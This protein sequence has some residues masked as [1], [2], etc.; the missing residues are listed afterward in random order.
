MTMAGKVGTPKRAVRSNHACR[1]CRTR[2]VKCDSV[3]PICGLCRTENA[4]CVYEQDRRQTSRVSHIVIQRLTE[5]L[6]EVE[7]TVHRLE[8]SLSQRPTGQIQTPP[9]TGISILSPTH[10]TSQSIDN[11]LMA[12]IPNNSE[13]SIFIEASPSDQSLDEKQTTPAEIHTGVENDGGH[14]SVYGPSSTFNPPLSSAV[15]RQPHP[16]SL[17]F[18]FPHSA[19]GLSQSDTEDTT[20]EQCRLF[21]NSAFQIQKE[22]TYMTERRFDLDGLDFDT[23]WHLL[24]IH[25]NH[26]HQAYLMTYRPAIMH[27]LATNGPYINKLL[28]NAIYLSSA[29]NSNRD[30]LHDGP[31]DQQSLSTKFFSRIQELTLSELENSSVASAVAFLII[32]SSLVSVGRQTAGWHYSGLGYR[33]IIDL[34]L[35]IDPHKL[36]ISHSDPS[37]PVRSFTEVDLELH[38]RVYWGAYIND[39][40]QALYFGRPP[41]LTAIGIEPSRAYLDNFEELELW[42]PYVDPRSSVSSSSTFQPQPAYSLSTFQT[43]IYLTDIMTDVVS[44]LYS[45]QVQCLSQERILEIG[46]DLQERLE[47]WMSNLPDHLRWEPSQGNAPP[48]HR[49]NPPS[50][51]PFDLNLSQDQT[52]NSLTNTQFF[53][54]G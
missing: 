37:Q 25:W 13:E 22:W 50:V 8:H 18:S 34:G 9:D 3:H 26:H 51:V 12:T 1:L 43:F 48:A 11:V 23:A 45:P 28:L 44:S 17:G 42:K 14:I 6:A 20:E 2:K 15:Y 21:A 39:K 46:R 32:G 52:P 36:R 38:R 10:A 24:Q 47:T 30:E 16:A 40:F 31:R 35:H 7:E 29:L 54:I 49:F 33:M 53:V 41:T 4:Q 19:A 5:K 27:S